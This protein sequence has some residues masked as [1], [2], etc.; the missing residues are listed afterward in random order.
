MQ[1]TP[2]A[3]M[4]TR[5]GQCPPVPG[6]Q[7]PC[8]VS[9]VSSGAQHSSARREGDEDNEPWGEGR[10]GLPGAAA[11]LGRA[12]RCPRR[13]L[14][15]QRIHRAG[16]RSMLT[17]RKEIRPTKHNICN[18]CIRIVSFTLLALAGPKDRPIFA[19]FRDF[20]CF[21]RDKSFL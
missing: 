13:E 15:T 4:H 19:P 1:A 18:N 12:A 9:G 2:R 14:C 3:G 16:K 6:G 17:K 7:W 11:L 5:T 8:R 21:R 10:G 20:G